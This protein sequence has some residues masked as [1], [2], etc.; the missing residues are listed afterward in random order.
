MDRVA[1]VQTHPPAL[2][3]VL[4]DVAPTTWPAYAEFIAAV[5]ALGNIPL[6]L[7]VVPDFHHQGNIRKMAP[8]LGALE[9][10]LA[11]GDELVLHGYY[12]DDPG[13]IPWS[14][15]EFFMRRLYTHEGEFFRLDTAQ[16]HHRLAQGL[17][18]FQQLGWPVQGFVAPAWL[19]GDGARNALTGLPFR[20]TSD[21][22]GLIRLPAFQHIPAPTLVWSARSP[23]RRWLSRRW[24]N[25]LQ[26]RHLAAPLLRLGLH[27]VD[28]QYPAVR[29]YW[30]ETLTTLLDQRTPMTKTAW[31]EQIR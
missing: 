17:A 1:S 3:L 22:R 2:C 30:L 10:R 27:P 18:L 11:R 8:F 23:A 28:M 13:P 26:R 19:L 21:P 20:Y 7:L 24:N 29:R 4:H 15:K 25:H 31:L 5:D 9:A 12:H 16:A 14:P 6:T